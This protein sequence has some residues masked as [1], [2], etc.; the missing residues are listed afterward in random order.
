[1]PSESKPKPKSNTCNTVWGCKCKCKFGFGLVLAYVFAYELE[2]GPWAGDENK[3]VRW[4]GCKFK[5][6][7]GFNVQCSTSKLKLVR[8]LKARKQGQK[9]GFWYACLL[10]AIEQ[11]YSCFGNSCPTC[12]WRFKNCEKQNN[13]KN[14]A[15]HHKRSLYGLHRS[16]KTNPPIESSPETLVL[17]T[18][19][20]P[21]YSSIWVNM[22][23]CKL[24][25]LAIV[26]QV[27]EE[28][29]GMSL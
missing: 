10:L 5:V 22:T 11:Y 26:F 13:S 25:H 9:A 21:L 8:H 15:S 16:A 20:P 18:T 24:K 28:W 19:S 3:I 23:P 4:F 6:G 27:P 1:M 17:S 2:A 14:A 7:F 12:L 29:S